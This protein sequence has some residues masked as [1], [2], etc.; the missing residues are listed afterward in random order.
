MENEKSKKYIKKKIGTTTYEV[1]VN[2]KET[3][4]EGVQEKLRR[5]ILS[6]TENMENRQND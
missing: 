1:S 6:D 2:Y 4:T 5:I 3:S